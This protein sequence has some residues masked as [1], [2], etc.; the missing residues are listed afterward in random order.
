LRSTERKIE[1]GAVNIP[2]EEIKIVPVDCG[3]IRKPSCPHEEC[4]YRLDTAIVGC[5][6]TGKTN[7]RFGFWCNHC[8]TF[9]RY[10]ADVFDAS[11][12]YWLLCR[13]IEDTHLVTFT[14]DENSLKEEYYDQTF[15]KK[16]EKQNG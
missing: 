14:G 7:V 3:S 6:L 2:P 4:D 9:F 13:A 16:E 10:T 1:M 5:N 8:K 11:G 15:N 12:H